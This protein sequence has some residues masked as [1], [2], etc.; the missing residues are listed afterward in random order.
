MVESQRTNIILIVLDSVRVDHCSTYNYPRRTTPCL[1]NLAQESYLFEQVYAPSSWTVPVHGSL[2]TGELPSTHGAHADQKFFSYPTEKTLAGKFQ[3][4]GYSTVSLTTNPWLTHEFGFGRG[5]D[6]VLNLQSNLPFPDAGDPREIYRDGDRT[7]D[8]FRASKWLMKGSPLKRIINALS[9]WTSDWSFPDASQLNKE[10]IRW[11]N[12]QRRDESFFLYANYMD[13]HEPYSLEEPYRQFVNGDVK[14]IEDIHWNLES[15]SSMRRVDPELPVDAYDSALHY[16]DEQLGELIETLKKTG[17]LEET[18]LVVLSD[19]GQCLGDHDYWGH[20]TFLY[21][22]LLHV[23]ALIRPPGGI[24]G[25]RKIC[26]LTSVVD[27]FDI[28]LELKDAK[29]NVPR[30]KTHRSVESVIV[31]ETKGKHQD[32]EIPSNLVS[33]SG[34]RAIYSEDIRSLHALETDEYK[35]F[36]RD[37]TPVNNSELKCEFRTIEETIFSGLDQSHSGEVNYEMSSDTKRQLRDLG[38]L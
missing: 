20:G 24:E 29:F 33:N 36:S 27:F 23:P 34:Y 9:V 26:N 19:H 6:K 15:L 31:S 3:S 16:L 5:F 22:E 8:L 11:F 7:R 12:E 30:R 17:L 21:D 14:Q 28:I 4:N 32:V 2:F 1:S 37:G 13:A 35:L 38:Y 18:A 10:I 25:P